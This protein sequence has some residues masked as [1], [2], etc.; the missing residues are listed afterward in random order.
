MPGQRQDLYIDG[1]PANG[2][3]NGTPIGVLDSAPGV[4]IRIGVGHFGGSDYAHFDGSIDAVRYSSGA[5]FAE[6]QTFE[7]A[8]CPPA[9]ET[10]IAV[11]NFSEGSGTTTAS[12]GLLTTP[13]ALEN[14]AEFGDGFPCATPA[15]DALSLDGA[16]DRVDV[17]TDPTAA[18]NDAARTWE[19]WVQTE[20]N[21]RQTIL[22]SHPDSGEVP[23]VL[24]M[25]DGIPRIHVQ[26]GDAHGARYAMTT[27]NDGEWHHVAAVWVP[28]ERLDL[29][30][31]GERSDGP[32]GGGEIPDTLRADEDAVIRIG[33]GLDDGELDD[34]FEGRIDS[35]RYSL[36]ARYSSDFNP[37]KCWAVDQSTIAL[38]TFDE[39]AGTTTEV[40]GTLSGT[41]QLVDGVEWVEGLG[42]APAPADP[43]SALRLDGADDY[44][45]AGLD[46]T[47]SATTTAR[48]WEAWVKTTRSS[49]Q[50]IFSRY[51]AAGGQEG[52]VLELVGAVPRIYLQSDSGPR[53][54]RYADRAVNDGEWHHIAAVWVPGQR[55]D[56]YVDGQPA[57]G[58]LGGS[59]ISDLHPTPGV[60]LRIGVGHWGV[61]WGHFGGDVDG[62]HY[63]TGARYAAG[64]A[65]TPDPSPQADAD[66]IGLWKFSEGSGTSTQPE[67]Q[68][69]AASTLLNG[70]TWTTGP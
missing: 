35:V 69:S 67:G 11:W 57:N 59:L 50:V 58:S 49:D 12:E 8:Q 17:G 36:G 52:F 23:W 25:E 54:Y 40:E 68:V 26:D 28:G 37:R 18:D 45:E 48:T 29:Y 9:D 62:V 15:G 16:D 4:T 44:V 10:T 46:P 64:T 53:G 19:A 34:F 7:P 30:V 31:D 47:A 61:L 41:A 38:L 39:A 13:A 21:E 55:I 6:N 2:P 51:R 32:L 33:A 22:A 42:C 14:G 43:D 20:S 63:S 60:S 3:L 27:V 70:P 24:D 1:E 56:L 65:F 5:R 66:T